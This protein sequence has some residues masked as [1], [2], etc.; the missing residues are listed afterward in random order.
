MTLLARPDRPAVATS[1]SLVVT[2]FTR[3][4]CP[5]SRK[6]LDVLEQARDRFPSL[7]IEAIDVAADPALTETYG[8]TAPVVLIGGKVRFRG[9]V[10]RVLLDRLLAAE[11]A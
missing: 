9:L 8:A 4:D 5:C 1:K 10:N 11:G 3:A 2:V 7:A 6:A